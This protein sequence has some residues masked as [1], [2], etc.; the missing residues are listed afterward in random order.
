MQVR[1]LLLSEG[2]A[3]ALRADVRV[4]PARLLCLHVHSSLAVPHSLRLGGYPALRSL[5]LQ[6]A[7]LQAVPAVSALT[8]GCFGLCP[9]PGQHCL[10]HAA[11]GAACQQH[12]GPQRMRGSKAV[13]T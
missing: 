1:E 9:A 3:E 2:D 13:C 11:A 5:S 10:E 7:G 8:K 12:G 6:R 4:S